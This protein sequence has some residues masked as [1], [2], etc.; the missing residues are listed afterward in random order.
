MKKK[1]KIDLSIAAIVTSVMLGFV[2]YYSF[3]DLWEDSVT[4]QVQIADTI[5]S[6]NLDIDSLI[7]ESQLYTKQSVRITEEH[8]PERVILAHPALSESLPD[9]SNIY[10]QGSSNVELDS[11]PIENQEI[12][13]SSSEATKEAIPLDT[14]DLKT[15]DTIV[16]NTPLS[17]LVTTGRD[18]K[19]CIIVVG[20]FANKTN[21]IKLQKSLISEG[22]DVFTTPYKGTTRVGVYQ[23]C[24][25]KQLESTL[26]VIRQKYAKDALVL[27]KQ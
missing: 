21:V 25:S 24:T 16:N 15:N 13:T 3:I 12:T 22:Y 1:E 26:K 8:S 20:A 10:D 2:L 5:E 11:T 4:E 17:P 19:S 6:D 7:V 27:E 9:S 18:E 23:S 14:I